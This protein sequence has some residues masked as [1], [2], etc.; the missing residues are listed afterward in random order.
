MF[1][2][3]PKAKCILILMRKDFERWA[4]LGYSYIPG[5]GP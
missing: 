5:L 4:A 3:S 1:L 2:A